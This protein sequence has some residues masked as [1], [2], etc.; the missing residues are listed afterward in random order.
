MKINKH[1][2][3]FIVYLILLCIVI[4]SSPEKSLL[5]DLF[6]IVMISTAIDRHLIAEPEVIDFGKPRTGNDVIQ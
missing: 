4:G 3:F 6:I 1:D 5:A 2:V